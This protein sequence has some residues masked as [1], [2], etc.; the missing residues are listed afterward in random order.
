MKKVIV[1]RGISNSGK[2]TSIKAALDLIKSNPSTEVNL[3]KNGK[4]LIVVISINGVIVVIAS[5]GDTEEILEALLE[6][7]K[8]IKWDV[9]V[10][11][12]K[13]RGRTVSFIKEFA[14]NYSCIWIDKVWSSE[15]RQTANEAT[16]LEILRHIGVD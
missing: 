6:A 5:A 10:C 11:A 7:I 4:D 3:L 13:S 14:K 9:L 16:A 15:D 2:T 8:N 1:V 12:T